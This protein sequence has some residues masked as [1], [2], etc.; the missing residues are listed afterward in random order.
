AA[1]R[2]A[3]DVESVL[4]LGGAPAAAR[5]AAVPT[6]SG[7]EG[8]GLD[9]FWEAVT[10]HCDAMESS[11][12]FE[13]RRARQQVDWTWSMVHDALLSRLAAAPEVRRISGEV[14]QQ[15]REGTLTAALAAQ[16]II[17]AFDS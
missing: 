8:D 9:R 13:A 17:D 16:A 1:H 11:G 3:R 12:E 4:R 6:M 2:A 10:R 14:E 15:V 5:K 7:L